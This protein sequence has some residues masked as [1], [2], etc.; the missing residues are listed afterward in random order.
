[1]PDEFWEC[2]ELQAAFKQ[3]QFGPVVRAYRQARGGEVTQA[4]IADW[5]GLSQEQVSR[6]ERNHSAVNNLHKLDRW[7]QALRIP[8]CYLWF[9]LSTDTSDAD[10][11]QAA[12][13]LESAATEAAHESLLFAVRAAESNVSKERLEHLRWEI[14]RLAVDYVHAPVATLFCEL[15][16]TRNTVFDLLLNKRQRPRHLQELGFLGGMV[17]LI[18]AHASQNVGNQRAALTQLHTAWTCADLADHDAL[19]AWSRG[20][21][22]LINEWSQRQTTA[23]ELA[24]QGAQF[25]SSRESRARLTAIEARAA[26][27]MG[28]YTRAFD[29]LA[30]LDVIQNSVGDRDEVI[31]FGGL[32]SFPVAKQSYYVGSTY[33]LLGDHEAAERYARAAIVAYETGLPAERSYGDEALARL[34]VVNA[35]LSLGDP[36]GAAEAIAPVLALSDDRRIRQLDTALERTLSILNR[37]PSTLGKAGLELGDCIRHY[38]AQTW[39][40]PRVLPASR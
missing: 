14:S 28:D 6:I 7:A 23:L 33:G 22:A 15:V 30:R 25:S 26:A 36:D 9:N 32:L 27:R 40:G 19:R 37:S 8:Q 21:A 31:E 13:G 4:Q 38:R 3:R 16:E 35:R 39:T 29:A 5:L 11:Q 2:P 18:L 10:A 34:D 17:C 1:M 12:A 20:S 24:G